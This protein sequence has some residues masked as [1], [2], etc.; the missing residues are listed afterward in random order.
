MSKSISLNMP[1]IELIRSFGLSCMPTLYFQ[2]A[3]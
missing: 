2:V 3:W 1:S